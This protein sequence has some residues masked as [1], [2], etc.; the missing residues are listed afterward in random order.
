MKISNYPN[1]REVAIEIGVSDGELPYV[2]FERVSEYVG[3]SF[4]PQERRANPV[5]LMNRLENMIRLQR[6]T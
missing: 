6:S 3:H 5:A 2:V 1:I 4:T